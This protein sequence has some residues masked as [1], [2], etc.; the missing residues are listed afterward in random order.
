MKVDALDVRSQTVILP[1]QNDLVDFRI[2]EQAHETKDAGGA[3]GGTGKAIAAPP[4][5]RCSGLEK[6]DGVE[7][8]D[9]M[10]PSKANDCCLTLTTSSGVTASAVSIDPTDPETTL[11]QYGTRG[12]ADSVTI[13][14][15]SV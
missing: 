10:G 7:A 8:G 4:E 13:G 12:G 15:A 6:D 5:A 1:L 14:V 2:C 9:K 11:A 3:L